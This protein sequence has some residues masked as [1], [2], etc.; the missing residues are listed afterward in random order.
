MNAITSDAS[1]IGVGLRKLGS[2]NLL[3]IPDRQCTIGRDGSNSIVLEGDPS[4]SR[5]HCVITVENGNYYIRDL[6]SWNGTIVNSQPVQSRQR[7]YYGDF[8]RVGVTRFE[9]VANH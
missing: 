7:V 5:F 9:F 4:V 8:L 6:H 2:T 1:K 3:S